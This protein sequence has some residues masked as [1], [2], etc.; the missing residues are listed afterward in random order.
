MQF[1]LAVR[2]CPTDNTIYS[3]KVPVNVKCA[4]T[5]SAALGLPGAP[6]AL[7]AALQQQKAD[8]GKAADKQAAGAGGVRSAAAAVAAV[9]GAAALLVGL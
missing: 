4:A 2:G 5:P 9:A 3:P 8:G 1:L 6:G 7:S